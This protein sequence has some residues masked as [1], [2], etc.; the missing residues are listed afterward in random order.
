MLTDK[1]EEKHAGWSE[2]GPAQPLA[3][4]GRRCLA[5]GVVSIVPIWQR[6][7]LDKCEP[8]GASGGVASGLS[9]EATLTS[10]D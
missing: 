2:G 7:D 10:F 1:A 6:Q 4:L 8:V 5:F 9:D 3:F